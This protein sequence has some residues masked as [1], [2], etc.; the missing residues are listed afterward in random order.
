MTAAILMASALSKPCHLLKSQ[1]PFYLR[2]TLIG[3]YSGRFYCKNTRNVHKYRTIHYTA[4][5][6]DFSRWC[7]YYNLQKL[8]P[9]SVLVYCVMY[10]YLDSVDKKLLFAGSLLQLFVA[11]L[12]F[13]RKETTKY[14]YILI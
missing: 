1:S 10:L 13:F 3:T 12:I 6:F 8:N 2:P 7:Q 4:C 11:E 9:Q 5:G 14:K